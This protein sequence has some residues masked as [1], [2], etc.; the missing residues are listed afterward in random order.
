MHAKDRMAVV[1]TEK[2]RTQA[3]P[4]AVVYKVDPEY[5]DKVPVGMNPGKTKMTSFP[6]VTDIKDNTSPLPMAGGFLLDR[7]GVGVNTMFLVWTRDEYSS[8][9]VT[10]K[11]SQIREAIDPASFIGV[12]V[13]LPMTTSEALADTAAVNRIILNGFPGCKILYGKQIEFGHPT[14][15]IGTLY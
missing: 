12:V 7:Q 4:R 13:Q 15:T 5:I 14:N 8:M 1:K 10:P 2:T 3:L 11:V 6:A 9:E